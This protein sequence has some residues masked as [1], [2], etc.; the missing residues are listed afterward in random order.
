M[1]ESKI[2]PGEVGVAD[3]FKVGISRMQTRLD[4]K[5]LEVYGVMYLEDSQQ[6]E[7]R[8][9]D[10]IN[11]LGREDQNRVMDRAIDIAFRWHRYSKLGEFTSRLL[12]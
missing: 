11:D 6:R 4:R 10:H 8:V 2:N 1:R 12:S 5:R 7:K 9:R 3:A